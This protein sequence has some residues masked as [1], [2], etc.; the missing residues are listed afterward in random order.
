[1]AKP[2]I[3]YLYPLSQSEIVTSNAIPALMSDI[4][5]LCPSGP[6]ASRKNK[7]LLRLAKLGRKTVK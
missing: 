2:N 4:L 5:Q 3:H 1:M 6:M 7:I